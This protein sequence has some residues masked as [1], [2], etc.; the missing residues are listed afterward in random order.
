MKRGVML[1]E[2]LKEVKP[3]MENQVNRFFDDIKI[4]RAGKAGSSLVEDIQISFY[5]TTLP[6]K[7]MALIST[8]EPNL[9][10]IKPFD[11]NA[12]GD[13]ELAI[14][15]SS[16]SLNPS[17]DGNVLRIVLPP[18][19]RERREELVHLLHQ[20]GEETRV[21]LRNLRQQAWQKVVE[22]ERIKKISEDDRYKG[23]E[24]LNK[25]IDEFNKKIAERIKEKEEE[26][27]RV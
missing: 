9:I 8:P 21:A 19:S 10:L 13:I 11:K 20:K 5:G 6:L 18:L 27:K 7:Q 3:K 1:N 14:R 17:N 4:L 23:E 22:A 2:I 15:N 24:E 12:L 16:L 26:L 25:M